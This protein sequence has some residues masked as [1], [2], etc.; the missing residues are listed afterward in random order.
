MR[1]DVAE[2]RAVLVAITSHDSRVSSPTFKGISMRVAVVVAAMLFSAPVFAQDVKLKSVTNSIGMELIEIPLGESSESQQI[3]SIFLD[4]PWT[5]YETAIATAEKSAGSAFTETLLKQLESA[6]ALGDLDLAESIQAQQKAFEESGTIPTG[7][8]F[9]SIVMEIKQNREN[10]NTQ[11]KE[12]YSNA[13]SDLTKQKSFAE[14]RIVKDEMLV[15][16]REAKLL[17]PSRKNGD[18]RMGDGAGVAVTLTK[19]FGLGKHEVT[20]GQWKSVMG[21]EPWGGQKYVTADKDCPA[22]FVSYFVAVEFCEK[23][24]DLE[25]KSGKLKANEEYRLPSE[26]EWEYACRAGTTTAYSFGDD[27]KQLGEYAWFR[28]NAMNAGE[29]YAHKVGWKKPNPWGLHDMHGNVWEWCSDWYGDALSG[30]TDPIGPDGRSQPIY[31]VVFRVVK[32]SQM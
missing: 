4:E 27:E 30:G 5:K 7:K 17:R 31:S 19:P 2:A 21:T 9:E 6:A 23:L 1:R 24:T 28:G 16:F 20:H 18:F 29:E 14:A 25:R 12:V 15:V 26:A 13:I 32:V 3:L 10:A 11:L 22:T 8:S